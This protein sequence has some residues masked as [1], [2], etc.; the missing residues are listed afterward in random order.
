MPPSPTT[1]RALLRGLG[2]PLILALSLSSSCRPNRDGE[3]TRPLVV[4]LD[5]DFP[6]FEMKD[7]QG[8]LD[9]IS[10]AM[11]RAIGSELQR[12]VEFREIAFDGLI[13]ALRGGQVDLVISSLSVKPERAEVIDFSAPYARVD[14]LA[15]VPQDGAADFDALLHGTGAVVVLNGTTAQLWAAEH[16]PASRVRV[17]EQADAAAA[18]VASG[19]SGAWIYDS[20]SILRYQEKFAAETRVLQTPLRGESWAIGLRK[21]DTALRGEVDAALAQLRARGD[22]AEFATAYLGADLERCRRLG[23]SPDFFAVG[24]AAEPADESAPPRS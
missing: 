14:L 10:V 22:F 1:R 5:P 23:L 17:L 18:E 15:L 24:D 11:A 4:G 8:R 6:P 2:L 16:L 3:T 13:Q 9:G 19:R 12:P 7:E 20:I 21:G